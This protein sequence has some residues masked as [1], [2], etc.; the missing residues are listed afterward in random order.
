[1]AVIARLDQKSCSHKRILEKWHSSSVG[2]PGVDAAECGFQRQKNVFV[3]MKG[4]ARCY[5]SCASLIA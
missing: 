1:M 3:G 2:A 4:F 5:V